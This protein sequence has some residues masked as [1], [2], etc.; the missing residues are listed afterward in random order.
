MKTLKKRSPKRSSPKR[1][2]PKTVNGK[3]STKRRNTKRKLRGGA[4]NCLNNHTAAGLP[5]DPIDLNSIPLNKII[6]VPITW[7]EEEETS[8]TVPTPDTDYYCFN[9]TTLLLWLNTSMKNPLTNQK[10]D[11]YQAKEILKQIKGKRYTLPNG[12]NS[13]F[14]TNWPQALP[15]AGHNEVVT[16][17][18]FPRGL[19]AALYPWSAAYY[20]P[21]D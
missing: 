10:F 6:R 21:A 8:A 5:I 1:G 9:Q 11:S 14:S 3:R 7:I 16:E 13:P 19:F 17:N 20:F 12:Y 4:G 18:P 15:V 2:S